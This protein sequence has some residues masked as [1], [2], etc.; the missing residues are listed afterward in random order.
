MNPRAGRCFVRPPRGFKSSSLSWSCCDLLFRPV[1]PPK[2]CPA[3]ECALL[4][5]GS[6]FLTVV[7]RGFFRP[8]SHVSCARRLAYCREAILVSGTEQDNLSNLSRPTGSTLLVAYQ[9]S[10]WRG[11]AGERSLKKWCFEDFRSTWGV[12]TSQSAILM[13]IDQISC[14]HNQKFLRMEARSLVELRII[15]LLNVSFYE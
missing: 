2:S 8:S 9:G 10:R 5:V 12:P 14:S 1:L 13:N 3:R 11:G 6:G 15:R 4:R 7:G